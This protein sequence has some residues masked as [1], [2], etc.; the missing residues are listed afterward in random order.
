MAIVCEKF[1]FAFRC[2]LAAVL[3]KGQTIDLGEYG[4]TCTGPTGG[5]KPKGCWPGY[6]LRRVNSIGL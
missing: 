4:E 1:S 2:D 5:R 3:Q 6:R